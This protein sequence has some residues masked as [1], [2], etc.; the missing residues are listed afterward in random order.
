MIT[1]PNVAQKKKYR[2]HKISAEI[3]CSQ[4]EDHPS[5]GRL[6][7]NNLPNEGFTPPGHNLHS[8]VTDSVWIF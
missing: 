1:S 8:D 2:E 6:Y 4:N 5:S 3:L 7:D